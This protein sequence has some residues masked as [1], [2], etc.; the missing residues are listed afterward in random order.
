MARRSRSRIRSKSRTTTRR[1]ASV[2]ARSRSRSQLVRTVSRDL[3]ALSL[4]PSR[5]SQLDP[6]IEDRRIYTPAPYVVS[7]G[8][9]NASITQGAERLRDPFLGHRFNFPSRVLICARRAV[10]KEVTPDRDWET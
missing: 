8:R 4:V 1:V 6:I 2:N 3:P 7:A 9:R 5:S 10:R